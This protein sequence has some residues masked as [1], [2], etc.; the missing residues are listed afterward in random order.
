MVSVERVLNFT[1][2][3]PESGYVDYCKV[4]R[5]KEEGFDAN[6]FE[7]GQIEF[8]EFSAQYRKD[9]PMVLKKISLHIKEGEKVGIV[10]R[11]GAGKSTLLSCLLRI[12][13]PAEGKIL[14]DEKD[15]MEF[16][17]KD[18]RSNLTMIDQE[19]TLI[20][21]TFRENL[22]PSHQYSEEQLGGIIEECN[23]AEVVESKG[24]LDA[25]VTNESL[26]VGEKQLLCICRAFL[27][28]SKIVLIDEATAN[29][30]TKNDKKIQEV[31]ATKFADST[32]L[33]IAHRLTTLKNSDKILVLGKGEVL[34]WGH[35]AELLER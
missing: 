34:E 27:K 31:I 18:L 28:K 33:T 2:I 13:E 22:D 23:L 11:T 9:L 3:E 4:W 20:K 29:I 12:V 19:P 17:L 15:L 16:R 7:K 14:V 10:G 32:V 6:A 30:D 8:Q 1:K 25:V 24:G 35:P 5:T 26:S 21:G